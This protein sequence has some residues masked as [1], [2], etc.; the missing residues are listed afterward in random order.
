MLWATLA[1]LIKLESH[2]MIFTVFNLEISQRGSCVPCDILNWVI[3]KMIWVKLWH[4]NLKN[5]HN[6]NYYTCPVFCS[7]HSLLNFDWFIAVKSQIIVKL[8]GFF[9]KNDR[10]ILNIEESPD[11]KST[12]AHV[13]WNASNFAYSFQASKH[14]FFF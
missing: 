1:W 13:V 9:L 5:W 11:T 7:F 6:W 4:W 14:N 3:S 2:D 8:K 12:F 10:P